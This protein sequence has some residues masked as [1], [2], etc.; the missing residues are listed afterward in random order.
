MVP[1][2]FLHVSQ[3]MVNPFIHKQIDFGGSK[4]SG[5]RLFSTGP[6]IEEL[7]V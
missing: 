7:E 2:N 5:F 3:G 1:V 6:V 4:H